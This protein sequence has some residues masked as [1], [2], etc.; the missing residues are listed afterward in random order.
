SSDVCSSDLTYVEVDSITELNDSADLFN[1]EI[2]GIDPGAGL[3][4]LTE[5]VVE[6]Y[7]LNLRLRDGSDATMTAALANAVNNDEPIVVTAWT[8]HWK[9]ARWDLKYPDD[10]EGLYGG[11]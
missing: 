4:G 8:P 6:E 3:Q 5:D 10:P 9:F 2:I 7:D 1:N 11:A